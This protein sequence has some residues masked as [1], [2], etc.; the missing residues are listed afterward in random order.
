VDAIKVGLRIWFA[1]LM[2]RGVDSVELPTRVFDAIK[3]QQNWEKDM[4]VLVL[5]EDELR[6]MGMLCLRSYAVPQDEIWMYAKG[7]K[8][9]LPVDA[10]GFRQ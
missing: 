1:A 5:G 3:E 7:A 2:I 4:S 9:V 6:F 10:P 8:H